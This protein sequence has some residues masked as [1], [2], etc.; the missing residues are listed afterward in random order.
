M[1]K[2]MIGRDIES[3]YAQGVGAEGRS[4]FGVRDLR[5]RRYPQHAV[6]FDI[7]EGEILALA[8]LV[9]AGR[10]E[11]AHAI[12]GVEPPAGGSL[13]LGG[14]TVVVRSP[15]DA[16]RHGIYLVPEDRRRCG[17]NVEELIRK[18]V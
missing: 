13:T 9:G 16:I 3:F 18:N 1:V 7:R 12:F 10:S 2:M 8:G 5:T 17:L 11:V 15:R 4:R 6:S 14:E